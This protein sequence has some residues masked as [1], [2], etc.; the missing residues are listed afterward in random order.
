MLPTLIAWLYS[1]V[2]GNLVASFLA[3]II[4]GGAAWFWKIRPHLRAQAEHRAAE[5]AH[6][7]RVTAQLAAL[8]K[9]VNDG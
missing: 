2:W 5:A 1:N 4:A 6:R 7:D 9:A 3:W 8:H